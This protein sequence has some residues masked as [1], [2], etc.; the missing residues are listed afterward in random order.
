MTSVKCVTRGLAALA[1]SAGITAGFLAPSPA[2]A[3][4]QPVPKRV[5]AYW[6]A[7][8]Q[9][10]K[11]YAWGGT[12]PWGYDCS[13]LVW[14]AY[15]HVGITLPRSTYGMLAAV[16]SGLLIPERYPRKGDPAFYGPGH[17]ELYV[18]GRITYGALQSGSPVWWHSFSG[19]WRPTEYFR[20]RGAG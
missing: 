4:A 11:P 14:A 20:V 10:G 3:A 9:E 2:S 8:T 1:L 19:W 12:G 5:A 7:T 13:G 15:R 17:V 6:W 16:W 18:G